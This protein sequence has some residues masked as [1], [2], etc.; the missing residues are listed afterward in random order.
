MLKQ[1]KAALPASLLNRLRKLNATI[2]DITFGHLSKDQ[3]HEILAKHDLNAVGLSDF[4]SPLPAV[5]SLEK[6]KSRW[7]RPSD[8][9]GLHY[10]LDAMKALLE[11]LVREYGVDYD[12]LPDEEEVRQGGFGPGFPTVDA[13]LL[14]VMLRDLKSSRYIEV[15][16][17]IS[18]FYASLAAQENRR[19]GHPLK[20]TCIDPYPRDALLD[21]SSIEIITSEVQAIDVAFFECLGPRDVLFIDSSHILKVDG[22]VPYLYLEVIPR[23]PR[24]VVIHVHDVHFPYNIPYPPEE[25]IFRWYKTRW[26]V[27]WNEA[28]LLQA[29]LAYNDAYAITLSTPLLRFFDE[30]FLRATIPNYRCVE[31]SDYRTHFGSIW[32]EKVR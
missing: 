7:N 20:I 28:M 30:A 14:F 29:F 16:S 10:D 18:S 26:P 8:L 2:C 25:Y 19:N 1:A 9:V 5:P 4:Y 27:F 22:D 13:M 3:L 17:G 6:T 31:Q 15:G 32:M 23:L 21:V 24:G 11:R 12:A